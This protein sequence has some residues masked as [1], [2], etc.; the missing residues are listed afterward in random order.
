VQKRIFFKQSLVS[1]YAFSEVILVKLGFFKFFI[2]MVIEFGAQKS[3]VCLLDNKVFSKNE[4]FAQNTTQIIA[5]F[6]ENAQ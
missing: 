6:A 2:G 1:F 3:L 5:D 4:L